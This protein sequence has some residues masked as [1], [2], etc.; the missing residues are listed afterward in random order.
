M[1]KYQR[2]EKASRQQEKE[3]QKWLSKATEGEAVWAQ[4]SLKGTLCYK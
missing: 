3:A 4:E 2:E 1:D